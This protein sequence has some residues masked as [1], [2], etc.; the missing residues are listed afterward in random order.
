VAITVVGADKLLDLARDLREAGRT[1]LR[2][3]LI[4]AIKTA[5]RFAV[6]EAKAEVKALPTHGGKHRGLRAAA[7]RTVKMRV[8]TRAQDAGVV[9]T[10]GN[11]GTVDGRLAIYMDRGKWRHPYFADAEQDRS[12]WTWVQQT[13][14]P[15]WFRQSMHRTGERAQHEIEGA[16]DAVADKIERG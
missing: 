7:A 16:M 8:R 6:Q 15:G 12:E 14:R 1:D 13:I 10:G 5:G 3:E 4:K 9:I 2:R 11:P